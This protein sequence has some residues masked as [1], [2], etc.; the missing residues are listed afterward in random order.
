LFKKINK[1][2]VELAESQ[3]FYLYFMSK[4]PLKQKINPISKK[5]KN[6]T[7][8]IPTPAIQKGTPQQAMIKKAIPSNMVLMDC[9][10]NTP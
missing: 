3:R 1:P 7:A 10:E 9:I 8:P 4:Y 6:T 2:M 5:A